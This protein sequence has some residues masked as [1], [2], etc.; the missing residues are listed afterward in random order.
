MSSSPHTKCIHIKSTNFGDI[1]YRISGPCDNWPHNSWTCLTANSDDGRR[2]FHFGSGTIAQSQACIN[3]QTRNVLTY[4]HYPV[5]TSQDECEETH[6]HS[7][8]FWVTENWAT[9]SSVAEVANSLTKFTSR[10]TTP[11]QDF[12]P[13]KHINTYHTK[14][15]LTCDFINVPILWHWLQHFKW[16]QSSRQWIQFINKLCLSWKNLRK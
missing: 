15:Q 3:P 16:Q 11:T 7:Q 9:I 10:P 6:R 1:A 4:L 2:R 12:E 5:Y 8:P 13:I 14:F